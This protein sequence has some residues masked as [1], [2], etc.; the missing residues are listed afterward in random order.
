MTPLSESNV[1]NLP[2][3]TNS[4]FVQMYHDFFGSGYQNLVHIWLLGNDVHFY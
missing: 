1:D 4:D 3:K 2:Q